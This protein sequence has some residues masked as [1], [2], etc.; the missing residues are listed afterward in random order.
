MYVQYKIKRA[1]T[2]TCILGGV[3]DQGGLNGAEL[4]T[5]LLIFFSTAII[6]G[7]GGGRLPNT[8]GGLLYEK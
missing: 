8:R 1:R 6:Q 4:V 3:Y 7:K 5:A 2:N